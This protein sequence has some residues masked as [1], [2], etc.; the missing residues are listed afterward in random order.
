MGILKDLQDFFTSKTKE[1]TSKL[2][3][4]V[5]SEPK[6]T[7]KVKVIPAKEEQLE[8]QPFNEL[9]KQQYR[10]AEQADFD[11]KMSVYE[12]S[13][14]EQQKKE[15]EFLDKYDR[16]VFQ[17]QTANDIITKKEE[18]KEA[19]S[20][21]SIEY[22]E[23]LKKIDNGAD[24]ANLFPDFDEKFEE[25]LKK[26]G[27]SNYDNLLFKNHY[28]D[29]VDDR[30]NALQNNQEKDNLVKIIPAK[31]EQP[32]LQ[33]ELLV[34]LQEELRGD[35]QEEF[36]QL[37]RENYDEAM[38]D[39]HQDGADYKKFELQTNFEIEKNDKISQTDEYKIA[40]SQL[41]LEYTEIEKE[42]QKGFEED[43]NGEG[44]LSDEW[45]DA[46]VSFRDKFHSTL[47]NL[48][49][50]SESLFDIELI[51][52]YIIDLEN[53]RFNVLGKNQEQ[54]NLVK[55]I[56]AT[57]EQKLAY[58]KHEENHYN[59]SKRDSIKPPFF[60]EKQLK[61][62]PD[63]I[64]N[65]PFG[66]S[67]KEI[68]LLNED[69]NIRE[70]RA[71]KNY[72]LKNGKESFYFIDENNYLNKGTETVKLD[73]GNGLSKVRENRLITK[74]EVSNGR[75]I[76]QNVNVLKTGEKNIVPLVDV[77]LATKEGHTTFETVPKAL[78]VG[79]KI[80]LLTAWG[81]LCAKG[82]VEKI[83]N[84]EI[85]LNTSKGIVTAPVY[86]RIEPLFLNDT[87]NKKINI[88]Y[89]VNE[90]ITLLDQKKLGL[91]ENYFGNRMGEFTE[92]LKGN[93]T[94]LLPFKKGNEIEE[95]K[96]Q[97]IPNFEGKPF[98]SLEKVKLKLDV[99]YIQYGIDRF[100]LNQ[101]QKEQL[102]NT[103]ELGLV[104]L[105]SSVTNKVSKLWVSVDREL[106]TIVTKKSHAI[107]IN[108][109]F[110]T[111]TTEEQKNK[112][113]SGEGIL[114]DI[115]GKNYFVI[116]SAAS[117][118]SDGLRVFHESKARELKLIPKQNLEQSDKKKTGIKIN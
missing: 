108:T 114:L 33:E 30:F 109:I 96:L 21:L 61:Q 37:D 4:D 69:H 45:S 67:S 65:H 104:N 19:I 41:Q 50:T 55:I 44:K 64:D 116:A 40:V 42:Y 38:Q 59:S 88:E 47:I 72:D 103:G 6:E 24:P 10:E 102:K 28:S 100:K 78:E 8:Q 22:S 16:E 12:E 68:L 29:V 91:H 74:E 63:W 62:V 36:A 97:I 95:G 92:L 111:P 87:Q 117:K 56:P 98:V 52:K 35:L 14:Y 34:K 112:L 115:K 90:T 39:I 75:K 51:N 13:V 110:G 105:T 118:N 89:G 82:E 66:Y 49:M 23:I 2:D 107:E 20:S 32:E 77:Y 9:E 25:T 86:A 79:D 18:Y 73:Y 99:S 43:L 5:I 84:G 93:K 17:D 81:D 26:L 85:E 71:G 101:K 46:M 80:N 48:G 53:D 7:E 76:I 70:N 83:S 113:K 106:D 1:Y 57:E 58:Y 54:D 60:T 15:K 3:F 11:A 31:E 27:M 94:S